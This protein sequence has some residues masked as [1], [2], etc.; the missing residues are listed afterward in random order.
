MTDT[1]RWQL[2]YALADAQL[3][4]LERFLSER[5]PGLDHDSPAAR[6]IAVIETLEDALCTEAGKG[7]HS[8]AVRA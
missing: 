3:G 8:E 7:G 6:A 2:A 4:T 1:R 5:Y